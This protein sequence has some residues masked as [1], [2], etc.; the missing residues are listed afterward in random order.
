MFS[1]VAHLTRE[2]AIRGSS[3]T[4]VRSIAASVL[5]TAYNIT[6]V[7]RLLCLQ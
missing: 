2:F 1:L 5:V 6:Q 4:L 3:S 7:A